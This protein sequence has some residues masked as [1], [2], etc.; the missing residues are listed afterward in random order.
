M[1]VLIR[2]KLRRVTEIVLKNIIIGEWCDF[3]VQLSRTAI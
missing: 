2:R 1:S 3:V